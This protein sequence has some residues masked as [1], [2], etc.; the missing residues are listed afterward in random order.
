MDNQG[1]QSPV[2]EPRIIQPQP[3]PSKTAGEVKLLNVHPD[4]IQRDYVGREAWQQ[5]EGDI[6]I[7]DAKKGTTH[8]FREKLATGKFKPMK[9][10]AKGLGKG[11]A[12][13]G[14]HKIQS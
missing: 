6:R 8:N 11:Q 4:D 13:E 1:F 5:I 2:R 12:S 14:P 9:K 7:F 3:S 10:D